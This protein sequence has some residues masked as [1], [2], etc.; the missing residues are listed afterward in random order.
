MKNIRLFGLEPHDLALTKL[1]RNLDVDRQDVQGLARE[2]LINAETL[3]DRYIAEFRP[4]LGSGH[5][6]HNLTMNLWVEMIQ[7]IRGYPKLDR[8]GSMATKIRL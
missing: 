7:E 2:G 6:R 1:D 3:R 5:S 4:N 8:P